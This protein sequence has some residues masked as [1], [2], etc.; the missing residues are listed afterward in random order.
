M[1]NSGQ[2][3]IRWNVHFGPI[4]NFHYNTVKEMYGH[5]AKL[6]FTDND[7]LCYE[8]ETEDAYKDIGGRKELFDFSDYSKDSSFYDPTNKKV[9]GKFKD[10]C[11]GKPMGG[12]V[13]LR[14]KDVF[15]FG[16][17]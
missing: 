16:E 10:E 8:I 13:G 11:A 3:C 14:S 4:K 7:S 1:F 6:L 15:I 12:F 5:K 17:R 9:P 2:A